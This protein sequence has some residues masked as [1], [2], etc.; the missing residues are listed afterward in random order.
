MIDPSPIPNVSRSERKEKEKDSTVSR[1]PRDPEDPQ[2]F[3]AIIDQGRQKK[4]QELKK[5]EEPVPSPSIFEISGQKAR[6]TQYAREK[7]AQAETARSLLGASEGKQRASNEEGGTGLGLAICK[8]IIARHGGQIWAE[9]K[10]GAG[11]A[12]IFK[13]SIQERRIPS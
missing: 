11:T 5:K 4:E 8:E 9:S 10:P 12:F 13:L 3:Q 2:K 1:V 6:S 7:G